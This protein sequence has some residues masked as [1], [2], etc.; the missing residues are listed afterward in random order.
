MTD[1]Q[2]PGEQ[3]APKIEFPCAYPI[4]VIGVAGDNFEI[5]AVAIV[6]SHAGKIDPKHITT[7]PSKT[8]YYVSVRMTITAT[9]VEQLENIFEDLKKLPNTKMVL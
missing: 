5:D 2:S 1:Q 3:P 4:K 9:G 6:E 8:N 7:N